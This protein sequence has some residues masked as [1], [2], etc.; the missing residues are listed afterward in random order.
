MSC[1]ADSRY[2]ANRRNRTAGIHSE[3]V[4]I[5]ARFNVLEQTWQPATDRDLAAPRFA[6]P[7]NILPQADQRTSHTAFA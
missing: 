7:A 4:T 2:P 6:E 1:S 5:R 3:Q